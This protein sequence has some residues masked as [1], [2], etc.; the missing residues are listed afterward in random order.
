MDYGRGGQPKLVSGPLFKKIAK[1]VFL[2]R[3]ITKN[4]K[5]Y[6]QNIEK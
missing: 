6:T 1:I 4:L 3:I 2:G 5:K